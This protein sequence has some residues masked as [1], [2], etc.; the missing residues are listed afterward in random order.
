MN[1]KSRTSVRI[2]A[3]LVFVLFAGLTTVGARQVFSER[4][5]Q[6]AA[7]EARQKAEQGLASAR[8]DGLT[9]AELAPLEMRLMRIARAKAPSSAPFVGSEGTTFYNG[10][11][12]RYRNLTRDT[13]H[14]LEIVSRQMK[15]E[16]GSSLRV[17]Q[18]EIDLA[19]SL[20]IDTHAYQAALDG[21]S[22]QTNVGRTPR[23]F[24][25]LA[26]QLSATM[27][28]LQAAITSRRTYVAALL[29]TS[30]NDL[31]QITSQAD[32]AAQTASQDLTLLGLFTKQAPAYSAAIDG[33]LSA[34]QQ[35]RNVRLAAIEEGDL[36]DL[37]AQ[38]GAD[39]A[40]TI[41][42]ELIVVSTEK[43][44]AY[45]YEK[46]KPIYDTPVTTGG[47]ELPTYHGVFHMYEKITPFVFH[48]PFPPSSPYYY[49]P[50]PITFWMPFDGGQGLHDAWWRSNFGPGSNLAPTD[51]GTGN[52][53]LGTH[54]C[55]NLPMAAAQF[56]W[57]WAPLGTTVA[58]I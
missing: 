44:W 3:A 32:S 12:R 7:S 14:A 22:R 8:L 54:G 21:F 28:P 41:P 30:H 31:A 25:R 15:A 13:R 19:S 16:T 36:H 53:I 6:S 56:V 18:R 17:G 46:G 37:I 33:A 24:L 39:A 58:V 47:P 43:Q 1:V 34:V 57:N 26:R 9:T 35:Q 48:S 50:T 23:Y 10:E 45:V 42:G 29:T 5:A 49:N 4:Q 20:D 38:M 11:A 52:S 2:A 40:R 51:L 55:V 27:A